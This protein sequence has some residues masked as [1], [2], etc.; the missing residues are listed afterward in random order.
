[1]L[2]LV[3]VAAASACALGVGCAHEEPHQA[4]IVHPA[5]VVLESRTAGGGATT[6]TGS[7]R[8]ARIQ[9]LPTKRPDRP[10]EVLGVI[11]AHVPMGEHGR[12]N[13]VLRQKAAELGADAVIGVDFNHGEGHGNEP[14]H[15]SGL[16]IRY[17]DRPVTS[18]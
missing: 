6:T 1:M 18:D 8:V 10:A 12:A 3:I 4:I 9:I 13:D 11:D 16:A 14:T 17:L 15:L 5:P 2:R 7:E